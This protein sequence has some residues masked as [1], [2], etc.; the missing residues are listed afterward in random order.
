[1]STKKAQLD[2]LN[3]QIRRSKE[4]RLYKSCTNLVPGEG[5]Y[6]ARVMFIGESPGKQEDLTGR[7]FVG[8][9]G[10]LLTQLLEQIGL[11]REDVFI[12]SVVKCRPPGNRNP[13]QKE[14]DIS[15]PWLYKQI[16]LI[17]PKIIV[18]LGGIAL[19]A[20]LGFNTIGKYSGKIIVRDGYKFFL[21]YHP[22][23]GLRFPKIKRLLQEDFKKLK[24]YL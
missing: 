6:R 4:L 17:R 8:R 22:A 16:D 9:S 24:K 21:T 20:L 2:R 5:S 1:M 15:L 19:K 14:I 23:A 12:T 7:P 10:Q 13:S 3:Q 18:L 11:K